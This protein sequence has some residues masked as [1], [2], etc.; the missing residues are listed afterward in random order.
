M[1]GSMAC[2]LHV[3]FDVTPNLVER[4]A[5]QTICFEQE[6]EERERGEGEKGRER[7][8]ESGRAK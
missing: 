4:R 3:E 7:E 5:V 1:V 2:S 6:R 8:K